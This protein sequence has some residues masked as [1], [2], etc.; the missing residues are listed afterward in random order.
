M[1]DIRVMEIPTAKAFLNVIWPLPALSRYERM[2][3][4]T[5]KNESTMA[6]E[7][8]TKPLL[9][10]M[11]CKNGKVAPI[12]SEEIAPEI[13][14]KVSTVFFIDLNLLFP[15]FRETWFTV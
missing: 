4:N 15:Q 11:L 13:S 14:P 3:K 10:P 6:V 7:P 9:N 5:S 2:P 8:I 1:H 12:S